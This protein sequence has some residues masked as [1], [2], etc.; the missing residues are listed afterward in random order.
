K[1]VCIHDCGNMINPM[2]VEGQVMGGIAQ[3]FG[4]A[5]Y[6]RIEYDTD[7]NPM[8]ANFVDFLVPY[9][10]EVP[11]IEIIHLETPSPL[12]PLGVK[13]V[14]EAGCIAVGPVIASGIE[15]A[16]QPLKAGKFHHVPIT[17]RMIFAAVTGT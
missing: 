3:G 16:L 15:D 7:G 2:I 6:E 12:N 14:G 10:T 5:L 9:A 1:Y 13:G 8:N 17:T 11:N 4:G